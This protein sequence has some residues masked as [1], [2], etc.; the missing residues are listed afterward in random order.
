VRT[1]PMSRVTKHRHETSAATPGRGS[2][3]TRTSTA[4]LAWWLPTGTP[5]AASTL[6]V[7][8]VAWST[9]T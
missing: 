7:P 1:A 4:A 2:T 3:M 8:A 6:M 5:T 9:P